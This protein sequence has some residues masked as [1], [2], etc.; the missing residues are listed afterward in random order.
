MH[1]RSAELAITSTAHGSWVARLGDT[2]RAGIAVE[3]MSAVM[4]WFDAQSINTRTVCLIHE[5]N[6]ASVRVA[7][8]VGFKTVGTCEFQGH[9]ATLFERTTA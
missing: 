4:P 3:V 1:I 5:G 7:S 8:R 6:V 9:P 2:S